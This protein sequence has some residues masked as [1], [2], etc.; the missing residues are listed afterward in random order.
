ML[1]LSPIPVADSITNV[2]LWLLLHSLRFEMWSVQSRIRRW[3]LSD[4][5]RSFSRGSPASQ[6]GWPRR[7]RRKESCYKIGGYVTRRCKIQAQVCGLWGSIT[8]Q[9]SLETIVDSPL[10]NFS[11]VFFFVALD[12][13]G[14]KFG[15]LGALAHMILCNGIPRG[16]TRERN[17]RGDTVT[18]A[19]GVDTQL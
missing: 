7:K 13:V 19:L 2:N 11:T 8:V 1:D 10:F 3:S 17:N 9:V 12:L 15:A 4:R 5:V 14:F 6:G 16:M 18:H